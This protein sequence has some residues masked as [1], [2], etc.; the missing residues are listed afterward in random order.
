MSL[1]FTAGL[2]GNY[3]NLRHLI[4]QNTDV[5]LMCFCIDNPDSLENI[6]NIWM[7][8]VHHICPKGTAFSQMLLTS[9]VS[10]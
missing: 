5:F 9:Y 2:E 1:I 10:M 7:P 3:D 4:Y 8:E 6:K